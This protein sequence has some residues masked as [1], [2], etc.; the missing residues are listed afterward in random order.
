MKRLLDMTISALVLIALSP[1][2]LVLGL[3]I[4]LVQGRP[5]I[6][7]GIRIGKGG[8]PFRM[9]KFRTMNVGAES[10]GPYY[11]SSNDSRITPIGAF[12]RKYSIDELPQLINVLLGDM[13][14]VGPR[15]DSPA[16]ED[17]YSAEE[18]AMRH[19]VRPGITGLAQVVARNHGSPAERKRL[20][21]K[22]VSEGTLLFDIRIMLRTFLHLF[23]K[24]SF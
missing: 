9:H 18:W 17:L 7:S 20:D 19:S 11:T 8:V 24:K 13:S 21:L 15:P 5:V 16:Q 1:F 14:I 4:V 2:L 6:Y 10:T 12:F 23:T 3:V 22:Y